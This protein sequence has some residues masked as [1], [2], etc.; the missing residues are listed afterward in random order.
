MRGASIGRDT[1]S[2]AWSYQPVVIRSRQSVASTEPGMTRRPGRGCAPASREFTRATSRH[3]VAIVAAPPG[4]SR[5]AGW[6]IQLVDGSVLASLVYIVHH[7]DMKAIVQDGYGPVE[8]LRLDDIDP[9]A[10]GDDEVLVR[11]HAASVHP[12]VWHMVRG[13]PHILRIMGAGLLKPKNSVPGADVAGHVESVGKNVTLFQPGD[14]VF[15][16]SVRGHQWHNG[17]AYAEYTSVP[18]DQLALKP[19][20]ITFEQAAAVP[21]SGLIALQGLHEYGQI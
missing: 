9:P 15:G 4:A 13:L 20:N 12:D 21:T 16:E 19:A 14:E 10:V 6:Q 5:R 8:V 18:E 17:G 7:H 2:P 3:R 11:V 1:A